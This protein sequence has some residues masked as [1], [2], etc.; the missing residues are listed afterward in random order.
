MPREFDDG[1]VA[2]GR[3]KSGVGGNARYGQAVLADP[4]ARSFNGASQSGSRFKYQHRSGCPGQLFRNR[5]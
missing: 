5:S 3:I 2:F 1:A 4:F